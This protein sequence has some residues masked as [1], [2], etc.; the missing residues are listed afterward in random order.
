MPAVKRMSMTAAVMLVIGGCGV[1]V[2]AE[3]RNADGPGGLI[4]SQ[5]P[6]IP[7]Q[8]LV[9][10]RLCFVRDAH[11]ARIPRR[12]P[13]LVG[14][15]EQLRVLLEG[16]SATEVADGLSSALTG[17]T[18]TI[19]LTL[20]G[21]RATVEVGDRSPHGVRTDEILAFGQIVCTLSSRPEVGT[22]MFTSGGKPLEVPTQDGSLAG[23]ALTV[24]DYD[25]LITS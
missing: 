22:I 11:L 23:G 21:G 9:T 17:T 24:A 5:P 19:E 2:D 4:P 15:Q 18:S 10:L 12:V 1:P 13:E 3:P 14:A 20:D 6:M 8:G 7:D 25:S 16:P